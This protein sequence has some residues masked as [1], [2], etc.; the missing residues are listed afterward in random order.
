MKIR[1]TGDCHGQFYGI[2]QWCKDNDIKLIRIPYT[3]LST[4][5]L[6]DLLSESRFM[7]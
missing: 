6:E 4:L 5:K 2:E 7:M 1:I 3:H